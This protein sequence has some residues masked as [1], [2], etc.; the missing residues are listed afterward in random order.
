MTREDQ[1]GLR[2]D[3]RRAGRRAPDGMDRTDGRTPR[4][5]WGARKL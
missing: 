3:Q 1:R 5:E 2:R 4:T